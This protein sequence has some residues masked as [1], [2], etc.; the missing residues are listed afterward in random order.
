[1]LFRSRDLLPAEA[2]TLL[3]RRYAFINVWKPIKGPVE[4]MPLAVCDARTVAG[5]D[6]IATELRYPDRVGEVY[7]VAFNPAHRW[8]YF[9]HMERDE[10]ILIK[11]YDSA[12]D[13][14]ARFA[15]H[16]AFA[17]PT[18]RPGAPARESIE[19]RTIALY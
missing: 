2:E 16:S 10:A 1:V 13:G 8:Y 17:D 3:R 11:C 14:R 7:S 12:D 5:R 6:W 9:P 4:E 15:A 18:T 19:I